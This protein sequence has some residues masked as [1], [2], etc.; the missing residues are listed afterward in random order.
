MDSEGERYEEIEKADNTMVRWMCGV[1]LR[2]RKRS[3]ELR[4]RLGIKS[5]AE[6]VR[7]GRLGWFGHVERNDRSDLVSTCRELNDDGVIGKGRGRKM[8]G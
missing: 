7:C 2:D 8:W 4:E 1:T 5:V 3:V 6:M